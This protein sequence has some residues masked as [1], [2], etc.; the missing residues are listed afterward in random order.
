MAVIPD[1]IQT[2]HLLSTSVE[3]YCGAN[4]FGV[5]SNGNVFMAKVEIVIPTEA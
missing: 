2:K 4:L 3:R 5:I 1:E